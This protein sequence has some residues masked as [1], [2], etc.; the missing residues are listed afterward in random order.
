MVF[1]PASS[2]TRARLSSS[3]AIR[4]SAETLERPPLGASG[5]PGAP[6]SGDMALTRVAAGATSLTPSVP[7]RADL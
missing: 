5:P 1:T 6:W 2:S 3:T 7:E 4:G